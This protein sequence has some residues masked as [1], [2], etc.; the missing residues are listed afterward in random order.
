MDVCNVFFFSRLDTSVELGSSEPFGPP[1][2]LLGPGVK[3]SGVAGTDLD[4][5][6]AAPS[7][8][9]NQERCCCRA[10]GC[11]LQVSLSFTSRDPY[12]LRAEQAAPLKKLRPRLCS[13]RLYKQGIRGLLQ[14]TNTHLKCVQQSF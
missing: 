7:L 9:I 12:Q 5:L 10:E 3:Q 13:L 1:T 11:D 14:S 4:S 8:M 2:W 6:L